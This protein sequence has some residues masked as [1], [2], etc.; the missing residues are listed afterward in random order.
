MYLGFVRKVIAV[1]LVCGNSFSVN[2]KQEHI[3]KILPGSLNA[4]YANVL[5]T[6]LPQ[7]LSFW[8]LEDYE[9]DKN[10]YMPVYERNIYLPA[11]RNAFQMTWII[12]S[13]SA[14][15]FVLQMTWIKLSFFKENAHLVFQINWQIHTIF[16][17]IWNG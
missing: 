12:F 7:K 10:I 8:E 4:K 5:L 11:N 9:N 17:L 15:K 16:C 1:L 13:F 2:E 3:H 6:L 14:N